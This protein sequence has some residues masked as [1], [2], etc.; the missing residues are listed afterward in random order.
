M[1][2]FSLLIKPA[3]A[4]C[5][6]QCAYCFYNDVS[7]VFPHGT[8]IMTK[9]TAEQLITS[10][11]SL[12][13]S[14]PLYSYAWQGGEPTLAGLDF[15]KNIIALQQKHARPMSKISNALQTNVMLID[16]EWAEFLAR[17]QFLTG[18]SLDG[19]PEMHDL[20]RLEN[21]APTQSRVMESTR[22]LSRAGAEF[23]IL[24]LVSQSNVKH[25]KAVFD[26]FM[27]QGFKWLQFIPC[28]EVKSDGTPEPYSLRGEDWGDFLCAVFDA[29]L[30]YR[31]EVSIRFFDGILAKLAFDQTILCHLGRDCR[32]YLL[33]EFN[34]DVFPCDF[35]VQTE[36][37]LGNVASHAWNSM[38]SSRAYE[39]FGLQK[40]PL[41]GKCKH[42]KHAAIC[43]GD[44]LKHRIL[45]PKNDPAQLS[46]LCPGYKKFYDYALPRLRNMAIEVREMR[47]G[48]PL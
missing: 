28:V 17:H 36:T 38:R 21:G 27:E 26:Y 43:A 2:S 42:C 46:L 18:V 23:N 48:N 47:G 10:Y 15:Y 14:E 44:C 13:F 41:P 16:S 5:N 30:P 1:D 7:D 35:F 34:G 25:G 33:V 12:P 24:C 22:S 19:P 37:R 40:A 31:Y 3:S 29:W 8:G 4:H 9:E 6:L 32:Q 11:Q 39:A 20:Y 45:P